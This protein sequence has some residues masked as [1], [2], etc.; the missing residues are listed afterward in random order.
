MRSL[1]LV[2][3]VLM[4]VL[5]LACGGGGDTCPA[6]AMTNSLGTCTSPP[7]ASGYNWDN[8]TKAWVADVGVLV[9]G[10]NTLPAECLTVGDACWKESTANGT[11]K[12]FASNTVINGRKNKWA[13]FFIGSSGVGSWALRMIPIFLDTEADTYITDKTIAAGFISS[14]IVDA[15]GSQD[16]VRVTSPRI[17]CGEFFFDGAGIGTRTISCPI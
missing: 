5:L 6:P 1:T 3:A 15:K 7:A 8:I 4:S 9:V 16:G 13:G 14:A 10:L 2:A 11:I 12:Y 17:G